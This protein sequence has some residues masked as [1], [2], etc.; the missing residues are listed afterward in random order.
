MS[1]SA[2]VTRAWRTRVRSHATALIATI[3]PADDA[4]RELIAAGLAALPDQD[5]A[6][7]RSG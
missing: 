6:W 7:G 5:R 4:D 1:A 2:P 3:R